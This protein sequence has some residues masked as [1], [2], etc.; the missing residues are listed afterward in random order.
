M[1]TAAEQ[2]TCF[3]L[4]E[5]QGRPCNEIL[6]LVHET[7]NMP[8]PVPLGAAV[9]NG[10]VNASEGD[11]LL[12]QPNNTSLAVEYTA[13]PIHDANREISGAILVFRDVTEMRTLTNQLAHQAC[14]DEL[15]GL[16][17]RREMEVCLEHELAEVRRYVDRLS[18]LCFMD[19]DQFKLINDTCGHAAGDELLKQV[20]MILRSQLREIDL[21]SRIGG[22]EFAWLI[23]NCSRED[24]TNIVESIRYAIAANRFS[25]GGKS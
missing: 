6:K 16:Y 8:A 10:E 23:S 22:D 18:W 20:A 1:N 12:V 21:V 17:N 25:C 3:K 4:E 9:Q 13:A 7:P 5:A 14:H 15:T 2:L 11:V 19:M 24:A